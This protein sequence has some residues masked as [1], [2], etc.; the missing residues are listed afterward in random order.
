MSKCLNIT[1]HCTLV[2]AILFYLNL[3]HDKKAIKLRIVHFTGVYLLV[4]IVQK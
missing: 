4:W 1:K 3:C 2:S